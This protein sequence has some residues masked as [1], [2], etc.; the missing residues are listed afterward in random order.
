MN[1]R[2]D[3][4]KAL[5]LGLAESCFTTKRLAGSNQ[6]IA[7]ILNRSIRLVYPLP[8][9]IMARYLFGSAANFDSN[10]AF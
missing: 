4:V 1:Y 2:S 7:S 6:V 9:A 8:R 5:S 10:T 3:L